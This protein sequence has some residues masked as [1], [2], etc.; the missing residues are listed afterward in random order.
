MQKFSITC[1]ELFYWKN[2][3][4]AIK[5]SVLPSAS[6]LTSLLL[7][8]IAILRLLSA[9]MAV[10]LIVATFAIE[11]FA[12]LL[13]R[14]LDRSPNRSNRLGIYIKNV[15]DPYVDKNLMMIAFTIEHT[16][17]FSHLKR[18]CNFLF[19]PLIFQKGLSFCEM[20]LIKV[21]T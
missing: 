19:S 4:C 6:V 11:L 3:D 10:K 12:L 16:N 20:L 14:C 17:K 7:L 1:R 2:I 9:T 13:M 8:S 18:N 15:P 21:V 5:L